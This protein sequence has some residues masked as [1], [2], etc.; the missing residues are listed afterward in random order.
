MSKKFI[1]QKQQLFGTKAINRHSNNS[2]STSSSWDVTLNANTS[3]FRIYSD[4]DCYLTINTTANT[5]N[6]DYFIPA[7]NVIDLYNYESANTIGI[8]A[9]SAN[10]SVIIGEY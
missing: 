2:V 4:N 5:S 10:S 9:T 8:I 6:W 7:L 1:Q 3:V